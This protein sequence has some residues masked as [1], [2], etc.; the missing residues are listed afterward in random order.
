MAVDEPMRR[1]AVVMLAPALGQHVFFLRLQHGK[2]SDC[3]KIPRETGFSRENRRVRGHDGTL[4]V[5]PVEVRAIALLRFG[6]CT[7]RSSLDC[8]VD[9]LAWSRSAEIAVYSEGLAGD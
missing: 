3:L 6:R 9:P 1:V 8:R 2:S 4:Q 5:A 7:A